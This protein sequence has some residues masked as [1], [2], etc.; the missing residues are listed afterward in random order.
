MKLFNLKRGIALSVVAVL[1]V[2][3]NARADIVAHWR[4]DEASGTT[5]ADSGPN[6]YH[7]TAFG[8]ATFVPGGRSGN[9]L[10]ITSAGGGYV[11]MV[12]APLDMNG[13]SFTLSAW[14]KTTASAHQI[15]VGRHFATVVA[16]YFLAVGSAGAYGVPNKGYFY[17]SCNPGGEPIGASDV[18]TGAWKLLT[19][20]YEQGGLAKIYVDGVLEKTKPNVPISQV[21]IDFCVGAIVVS[22]VYTNTY[23]GLIDDVQIYDR[24]LSDNEVA[25]LFA[26]PGAE[27]FKVAGHVLQNSL[28]V[29]GVVV[30][31][32]Q[33]STV[34]GSGTTDANGDYSIENLAAGT[35]TIRPRHNDKVFFPSTKD[36]NIAPDALTTHFTAGN[37]GPV[38]ILFQYPVIYADQS[39]QGTLGLNVV[40]PVARQVTMS[41]NSFKLT[42]PVKVTIPA[43]QRTANFFVYGVTVAADT[44]V[45]VTATHQGLSATQNITVR[46]KPVLQTMTLAKITTKG[47]YG[48]SGTVTID[49]PAIGPMGLYLSSNNPSLVSI[50]PGTTAFYN[51]ASSKA[52][53]CKTFP[54][55]TQQVVTITATFYGSTKTVDL[56]LTP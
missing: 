5:A 12:G 29:P 47:G 53:Y 21:G 36:V 44:V 17:Q 7:G 19:A 1:T 52:F 49:Q 41:D 23:D 14:V 43:G 25:Y 37:I 9:A 3:S 4:F 38:S 2:A 30:D 31:A 20:T 34:V 42:S 18:N 51:G 11:R 39:R 22:G 33:N 46:P 26:H 27:I 32:E 56:T 15:A 40:T 6:G 10:S 48:V 55:A 54:V 50:S 8:N 16:G 13:K 35:Y 24:A 28:G 45:T